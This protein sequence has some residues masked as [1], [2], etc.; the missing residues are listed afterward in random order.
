MWCSTPLLHSTA[1]PTYSRLTIMYGLFINTTF[2]LA[3]LRLKSSVVVVRW[4]HNL[5][6]RGSNPGISSKITFLMI[7][8]KFWIDRI[9]I[10]GHFIPQIYL[11]YCKNSLGFDFSTLVYIVLSPLCTCSIGNIT[12]IVTIS[13]N[14]S[15]GYHCTMG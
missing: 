5:K 3:R 11:V 14:S 2:F 7:F 9:S 13:C 12:W 10:Y 15:Q 6:V 1:A 8:P 4:S